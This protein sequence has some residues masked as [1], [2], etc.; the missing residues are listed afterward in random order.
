MVNDMASRS[1]DGHQGAMRD[2]GCFWLS[3]IVYQLDIL[4][5]YSAQMTNSFISLK[6]VNLAA[7]NPSRVNPIRKYKSGSANNLAMKPNRMSSPHQP[8]RHHNTE[9][10]AS[11]TSTAASSPPA[12][13]PANPSATPQ[14]IAHEITYSLDSDESI[15]VDTLLNNPRQLKAKLKQSKMD[16]EQ[17]NQLQENYLRLLEQY[18]E[19]E[20]FIDTFRLG[21]QATK[22]NSNLNANTPSTNMF[23]VSCCSF[24]CER[25]LYNNVLKI[26]NFHLFLI[27]LKSVFIK[28]NLVL[29]MAFL[30]LTIKWSRHELLTPR[31]SDQ[32]DFR[33][34]D[35]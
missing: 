25:C 24:C 3:N 14:T 6:K 22:S 12:P 32:E 33:W 31:V 20:N 1:L 17:L 2:H 7:S 11:V 23:Q 21:N 15:I 28:K 13:A 27:D 4:I 8:H 16:R 29:Q 26:E 5:F 35:S 30:S 34:D 19:A 10:L 18:A 9:N